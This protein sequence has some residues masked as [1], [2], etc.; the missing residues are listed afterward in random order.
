M[1]KL[2]M[3]LDKLTVES[4]E[5]EKQKPARGTVEGHVPRTE[6]GVCAQ[7]RDW[8]CSYGYECTAYYEYCFADTRIS[9]CVC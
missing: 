3:D 5:A 7:T 8:Y 1:K 9:Y 2:R 4:F 6:P